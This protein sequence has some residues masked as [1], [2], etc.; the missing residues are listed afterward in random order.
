MI[1]F[2]DREAETAFLEQ[3]YAS[4]GFELVVLYGRRRVGKTEL[5]RR[6]VADK[7]HLYFLA[8]KRGTARNIIRLGRDMAE[9]LGEPRIA[10]TEPDELFDWYAARAGPRPLILIDEF[11]YLVEKDRSIPSVFQGLADGVLKNRG[12]MLVLCGSSIGMMESSVLASRSPLYGRR[13]GHWKV[14]PLPFADARLFFPGTPA[15]ICIEFYSVLGGVPHYLDKFSKECTT[16]DNI[17][18]EVLSRSGHLYE[19]IDFLL[20]E[21]LREPDAYKAILEGIGS[22]RSKSLEIAQAARMPAQDI[23]KYLKVLIR[24][25]IIAK[26][27]PV[28][29]GPRSKRSRYWISDPLFRFWFTFCEPRKS[30]LELGETAACRETIS[31]G[32]PSFVGR[33]FEPLCREFLAARFPGRW[34]RLGRWWGARRENGKRTEQEI[35]IVGLNDQTGEAIFGECK[36]S[37]G[38]DGPAIL[39]GLKE[40]AAFV[41]WRK[42]G[43][44]ETFA[45]FARS[46]KR[47]PKASGAIYFDLGAI[48]RGK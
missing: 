18:R 47:R 13:T 17:D 45:V 33:A 28:T 30:E 25:G 46:F 39:A 48:A 4:G 19:E 1:R 16:L 32:L 12:A 24:L 41:E 40:K 34:P 6:F 20:M 38:V 42:S 22:G 7:P 36:W 11:P 5:L 14:L 10:A 3:R 27:R 43:R 31:K 2:I 37:D 9:A 26:D 8:D 15:E 35:D 44:S 21:E 23:D 29:E